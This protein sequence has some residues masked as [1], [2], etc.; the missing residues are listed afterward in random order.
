WLDE[1]VLADVEQQGGTCNAY[2]TSGTISFFPEDGV[3][4]NN[5]GRIADVVYHEVG[6][7]IHQYILATGTFA[8]DVSEGSSDYVAA[9]ILDD[10]EL[11]PNAYVNG[12]YIRELETDKFY[13]DDIIHESHNDGLIWG[14]FLWNLRDEWISTYGEDEGHRMVDELFLGALSQGPALTDL[15]EAV[16]L[17]DD[18]DGDLSNSTPHACELLDL[19]D[20]H[21]LGAGPLGVVTFEHTPL[22]HQPSDAESYELEFSFVEVTPDCGSMDADSVTLWYAQDGT[23]LPEDEVTSGFPGQGGPGGDT[24]SLDAEVVDTGTPDAGET[25]GLE[26]TGGDTGQDEL[27]DDG[28][29]RAELVQ[30]GDTWT[31]TIPRQPAGSRVQ[32]FMEVASDDGQQVQTTH[33]GS[34]DDLF[35][36]WVG[37]REVLWCEGFEAAAEDWTH[38]SGLPW[39]P[40][41]PDM[42]SDE[43]ELGAPAGGGWTPDEAYEGSVIAATALDQIYRS[44][45]QQYLA[46]PSVAL[47]A[48]APML[49]LSYARWLTV[50]DGIYDQ[51]IIWANE[52]ELW[53]NPQ[54]SSGDDHVLDGD[55][56]R[57]DLEV[58][59]HVDADGLLQL[60]W[61][62]AS[63]Q[64]LEFGGWALDDVCLVSLDDPEGHYG[65]DDLEAS[66]DDSSVTIRWTQPWVLPLTATALVRTV[67]GWP[68]E[69]TDGLIVD[70]DL[71]P[72]P[73]QERTATDTDAQP[74]EVFNYTLFTAG[75]DGLD[76]YLDVVEGENADQGGV[77]AE[78]QDTGSPLDTASDAPVGGEPKVEESGGCGCGMRRGQYG[79][80]LVVFSVMVGLVRRR[81]MF[82]PRS[83]RR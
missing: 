75:R 54:T 42:Y 13:P 79:L 65:V 34:E 72:V 5:L 64:G 47:D 40:G 70:V 53:E 8:S 31:A 18:D 23:E 11:A 73:G 74:G 38:G 46:S 14:S 24:G 29:E 71:A 68:E 36:F 15:Y 41:P 50:E 82:A 66:D 83:G 30:D 22:E 56:T 16:V 44:D 10:P 4:C 19:L 17:A 52:E 69:L 26:D 63:D 12:D 60:T 59:D 21:G 25:G 76:W 32:Y 55:W 43:W 49:L 3:F 45:N 51:A 28:W 37:D 67:E 2:Y 20:Y 62:L 27:E 57:H 6:H 78:T 80:S 48:T 33:G 35:G 39:Q 9:T 61:S 81:P 58:A 7:G 77:P 1:M